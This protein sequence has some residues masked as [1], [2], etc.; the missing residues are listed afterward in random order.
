M[1]I[2]SR[3]N[4]V[5][6]MY[7][8]VS[9]DLKNVLMKDLMRKIESIAFQKLERWKD[10]GK[11]VMVQRSVVFHVKLTLPVHI[12]S[13]ISFKN[14]LDYFLMFWEENEDQKQSESNDQVA[15]PSV[16]IVNVIKTEGVVSSNNASDEIVQPVREQSKAEIS[17]AFGPDTAAFLGTGL[18]FRGLGIVRNMPS[19]KKLQNVQCY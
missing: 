16:N 13:V 14:D 10:H 12:C 19:F 4:Y 18:F 9:K 11:V 15:M 5:H 2:L 17:T 3:E 6:A 7:V 1:K 8:E